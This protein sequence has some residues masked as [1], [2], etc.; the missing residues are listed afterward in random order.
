MAARWLLVQRER[1]RRDRGHADGE[2]DAVEQRTRHAPAIAR[3]AV[4]RAVAASAGVAEPPAGTGIHRGDE[5][6]L[7]RERGLP[8]RAG[9]VDDAGL[10]RFAQRLEN[11]PLP[12]R[13][14]VEKK[15]SLVGQRNFTGPRIAAAADEGY[16]T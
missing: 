5:L 6:E 1:F 10:E 4:R 9:D 16:A 11:A 2:I 3:D 7:R 8:R 13:Q 14:F 15:N 12:L